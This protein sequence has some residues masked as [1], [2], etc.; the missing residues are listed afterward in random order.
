[1]SPRYQL[2]PAAY[3]VLCREPNEILLQLRQN[4]GFRDGFWAT[5]AAGHVEKGESVLEAAV[6]EAREELGVEIAPAD[7]Q[8]LTAMHRTEATGDPIDERVDFFFTCRRWSG[9]PRLV[10][11]AKAADLGWFPLDALP[12]P[13][14][15]H[16]REV[17][18]ALRTGGPSTI[19]T[20]GF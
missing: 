4:T 3:V 14:V 13:V 15:A 7:L 16:E 12:D 17:L 20:H 6:R 18:E 10:E 1:M 5:A 9:T 19:T 8:P 11:R 2:V